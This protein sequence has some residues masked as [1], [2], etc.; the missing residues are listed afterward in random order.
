[1][2]IY[3][4]IVLRCAGNLKPGLIW[5]ST[6]DLTHPLSYTSVAMDL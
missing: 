3:G 1:M 4:I 5:T 6:T 2:F